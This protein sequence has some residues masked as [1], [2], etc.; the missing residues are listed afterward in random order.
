M[1]WDKQFPLANFQSSVLKQIANASKAFGTL[2]YL[3]IFWLM[4]A[5]LQF[6]VFPRYIL[7]YS[8]MHLHN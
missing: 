1:D 7:L 5:T 2:A 6:Y 8:V 4:Y 3:H